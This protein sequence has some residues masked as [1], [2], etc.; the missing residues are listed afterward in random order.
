MTGSCGIYSSRPQSCRDF[1]CA[2]LEGVGSHEDR[3]DKSG[4]LIYMA[5]D[6]NG[7]PFIAAVECRPG[8]LD[9]GTEVRKVIDEAG[10]T[11][12]VLI[13]RFSGN[14]QVIA[15]AWMQRH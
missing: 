14:K 13:D 4:A 11:I 3:P 10:Y 8:V 6:S 7:A 15:P 5:A 9:E 1:K 2:W 12:R